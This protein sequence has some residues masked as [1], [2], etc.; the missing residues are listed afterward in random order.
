[1]ESGNPHG[2][3]QDIPPLL[4]GFRA[5]FAYDIASEMLLPKD[6]DREFGPF[7]ANVSG[8]IAKFTIF[9]KTALNT[10]TRTKPAEIWKVEEVEKGE[11]GHP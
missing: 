7:I 8:H 3:I 9:M 6:T 2:E 5:N 4:T 1:M 10:Y 11:D